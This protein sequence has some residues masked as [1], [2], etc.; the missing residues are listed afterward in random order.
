M[1]LVGNLEDLGLGDILQ[2]VGLSRKS[3]VLSLTGGKREGTIVFID[4]QVVRAISSQFKANLGDILLKHKLLTQQA[5]N[6]ALVEQDRDGHR[7]LGPLL[8]EKYGIPQE[9][10]EAI[11]KAQIERIVYS[12][13]GWKEG[14]FSFELDEPE[15][16]GPARLDPLAFMLEQGLSPQWLAVEGRRLVSEGRLLSAEKDDESSESETFLGSQEKTLAPLPSVIEVG[17]LFIIDDDAPTRAVLGKAFTRTGFKVE[18]FALTSELIKACSARV[19][20]G[21]RPALLID[22]IM[23]RLD[24]HGILGGLEVM[25]IVAEKFSDLQLMLMTDHPNAEAEKKARELGGIAVLRKPKKIEIREE[26]GVE[27]L[28][29]LLRE[30]DRH[31]TPIGDI[32]R[33]GRNAYPIA[34]DLVAEFEPATRSVDSL[35]AGSPGLYLLKG[36]LQELANPL[37]GGGVILLTLRFASELMN[38]A[39]IFHVNGNEIVGLG[40]FG[41]D[42]MTENADRMVRKLRLKVDADSLFARVLQL[43]AA[44][45]GALGSCASDRKL[46]SQLGG[47]EPAEVFLGP[48]VSEGKVVAILYGDNLPDS[49]PITNVEAFEIFLSQA[50]IAMERVLLERGN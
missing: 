47:Q 14:T 18:T 40:Q 22:L 50:G 43:K 3:G 6:Q 15:A 10:I 32:F 33:K 16:I 2:I 29:N 39:V 38:R 23:P 30:V 46:Q 28:Q 37:L 21:E 42:T 7:P 48:L 25:E 44:V 12:F 20:Q 9:K 24:G 45:R 49:K 27:A 41:L 35:P 1:S 17:P 4:G 19:R 13:F 36:M 11:I 8:V 5:L 31:L 26:R 34:E